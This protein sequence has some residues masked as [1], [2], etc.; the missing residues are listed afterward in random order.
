MPRNAFAGKRALV[1][2]GLGFIGSHIARRLLGLGAKVTVADALLPH[3]GGNRFN[4]QD[5]RGKTR[6]VLGDLRNEKTAARV[7]KGMDFVF[8][9]V[10]QTSHIDSMKNP[11][12]DLEN[13]C[14]AQ[15]Y[16]LE[17]CRLHSPE[18]KII[19][20]G[21]RQI[22]GIPSYLPVD[23]EHPLNPTDVNG[24]H[25]VAAEEYHTLYHKVYGL[26]TCVLRLTNTYGPA[27][28]VKDAKQMFLGL[29]IRRILSGE[30]VLVYG[31]GEQLRDLNYIDDVVDAFLLVAETAKADGRVFNLGDSSPVSLK[32]LAALLVAVN[33]GGRIRHEPFPED[34][35]RIDIKNYYGDFRLIA[36]TLGWKPRVDL[37]DGLKKTLQYYRRHKRH[38]W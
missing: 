3:L 20:A 11:F 7:V 31:D 9:L 8:N 21:T 25:K 23:E 12:S 10:G 26:R 38:Y 22:Y 1:A 19:F 34:L 18:T 15:L 24:I 32:E 14:R 29:W 6:V 5:I 36:R 35:K 27:M 16:L 30:E 13:N 4:V 2:G 28:R 33:R 37:S 17:A